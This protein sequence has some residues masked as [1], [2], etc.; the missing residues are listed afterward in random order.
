MIIVLKYLRWSGESGSQGRCKNRTGA[1]EL[2]WGFH[3][4]L[5]LLSWYSGGGTVGIEITGEGD[6]DP[7]F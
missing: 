4:P 3:T 7:F 1:D 5:G 2:S 6:V